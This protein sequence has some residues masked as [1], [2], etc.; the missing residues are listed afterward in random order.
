MYQSIR[1]SVY[2]RQCVSCRWNK[3][4]SRRIF[5]IICII[6]AGYTWDGKFPAAQNRNSVTRHEGWA[7][8]IEDCS[9]SRS[10]VE[11]HPQNRYGRR[12]S[13]S[14]NPENV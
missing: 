9:L 11:I 7:T 8:E 1:L 5:R 6:I 2:R 3:Y 14:E 12:E 13:F 4:I 10:T